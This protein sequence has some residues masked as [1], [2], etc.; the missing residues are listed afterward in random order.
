MDLIVDEIK[1]FNQGLEP[2]GVPY[3]LTSK[4]RRQNQ[5]AGTVIV[6][7]KSEKEANTVIQHSIS[8]AG[9]RLKAEKMLRTPR[10]SQCSR[11]LGFGHRDIKCRKAFKCRL[12]AEEYSSKQHKCGASDS[13]DYETYLTIRNVRKES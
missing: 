10:T 2:V 3:W 11:C 7:F 8:I 5:R 13:K 6:A 4:E 9:L 12:C 1:T